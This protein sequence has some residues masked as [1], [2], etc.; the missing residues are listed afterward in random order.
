MKAMTFQ[1]PETYEEFKRSMLSGMTYDTY[2]LI[3]D[4]MNRRYWLKEFLL[5]ESSKV[6]ISS[7]S[8][9]D[10][11]TREFKL[12][13]TIRNKTRN[14]A[15]PYIPL[16][17][18]HFISLIQKA[19]NHIDKKPVRFVD[20]GCGIGDKIK[21]VEYFFS[22]VYASGIEYNRVLI[23]MAK[24]KY[25]EYNDDRI[26]IHTGDITKFDFSPYNLIYAYNPIQTF[27]GMLKFF[28]NVIRTAN[29]GT[30][31]AFANVY[32]GEDAMKRV[33]SRFKVIDDSGF[34]KVYELTEV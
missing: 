20:A 23:E 32:S 19:M 31:C 33:K 7:F 14:D 6:N 8:L 4:R 22:Y 17:P 29:P 18:S 9:N 16:C 10:I 28:E 3:R 24:A 11:L 27:E 12:S 26:D 34:H 30:I 1:V 5:T 21:L 25:D 13:N 2:N 15:Y